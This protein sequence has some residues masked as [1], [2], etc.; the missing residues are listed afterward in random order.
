MVRPSPI[1]PAQ[2]LFLRSA[3]L[4]HE[5]DVFVPVMTRD[6]S[7][8][9]RA[10]G[11]GE[12]AVAAEGRSDLGGVDAG[13]DGRTVLAIGMRVWRTNDFF[14]CSSSSSS[15]SSSHPLSK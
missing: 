13:A 11:A 5:C 10:V 4:S 12:A 2:F 1:T 8:V 9:T 3:L 6:E 7:G 14:F 15:S